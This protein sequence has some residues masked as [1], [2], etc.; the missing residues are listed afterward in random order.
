MASPSELEKMNKVF[1]VSMLRHYRSN[2]SHV[3][4]PVDV[5]IKPDMSYNEEPSNILAREIKELRNKWVAL[6]K[7]CGIVMGL[8]RQLGN[9]KRL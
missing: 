8:K 1:H 7:Y 2:P 3:I 9:K 6:V 5:E 4:S